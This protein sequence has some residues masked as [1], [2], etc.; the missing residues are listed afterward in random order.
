MFLLQPSSTASKIS[1]CGNF[2]AA[3]FRERGFSL[4][5][6]FASVDAKFRQVDRQI[7]FDLTKIRE[8]FDEI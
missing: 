3:N 6:N 1:L 2:A 7:S 4:L 5:R 8:R